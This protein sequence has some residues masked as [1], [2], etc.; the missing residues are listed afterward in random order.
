MK[1]SI[2][3]GGAGFIGSRLAQR[4]IQ[5]GDIVYVLDDLSTGYERNVPEKAVFFKVDVSDPGRIRELDLPGKADTVYHFAGQSSGEA[6]FDDP[7]GDIDRNY[8]ATYN[9][10]VASEQMNA[11]RFIY[12]S[13]MSVYGDV[14]RSAPMVPEDYECNPASYYGCNK[15]ASEKFINV[16]AKHS[17]IKPTIFRFFN[18]YGPG[19]NMKNMKQ[20]ML[21]IYMSYL[22]RDI[23]VT[24]K[25]SLDRFRDFIY[26]DDL[27]DAV[28]DCEESERTFYETFNLGTGIKTTVS[29]LL[30]ALLNVFGKGDFDKWVIVEGNTPGDIKGFVADMA[31]LKA[32]MEWSPVYKIEDGIKEMKKWVDETVDLWKD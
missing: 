28:V 18:V 22:I 20:G 8:R 14:D 12:S 11:K 3:T 9:M 1:T 26:I 10:L 23:P 31:K 27:L 29:R 4:L 24:V 25:G 5:R 7:S 13:S 15:F 17:H 2:I 30:E 16:F 32:R 19:Q 21:S 6:S